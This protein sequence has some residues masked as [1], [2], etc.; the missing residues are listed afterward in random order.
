MGVGGLFDFV[1]FLLIT[2]GIDK[3]TELN[4]CLLPTFRD[5]QKQ[6]AD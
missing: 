2:V 4:D 6:L 5:V 3:T 1:V